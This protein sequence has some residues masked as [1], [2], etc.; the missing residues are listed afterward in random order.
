MCT[1]LNFA[2]VFKPLRTIKLGA[3][4]P[5]IAQIDKI[6]FHNEYIFILDQDGNQ[7]IFAFDTTG[8]FLGTVGQKGF[9]P[10]E[11]EYPED[12]A[13]NDTY[14]VICTSD[15]YLLW[16]DINTRQLIKRTTLP[17]HTDAI[18]AI[19]DGRFI[20]AT[21]SLKDNP[22]RTHLLELVSNGNIINGHIPIANPD[23]VE[24]TANPIHKGLNGSLLYAPTND[25]IL[26][27][28]KNNHVSIILELEKQN[29]QSKNKL[30]I[31]NYFINAPIIQTPNH[32]LFFSNNKRQINAGN[33][34]KVEINVLNIQKK[35]LSCYEKYSSDWMTYALEDMPIGFWKDSLLIW[36][37]YADGIDAFLDLIKDDK[38]YQKNLLN[39]DPI[40]ADV[41]KKHNTFDNPTLLLG[42]WK[43]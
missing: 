12:I 21:N 19:S 3:S 13:V 41:I 10:E 7:A 33:P 4:T 11:Y 43:P 2:E 42:I 30:G 5:L 32:I 25:S 8:I 38:I 39:N 15:K 26:Y 35:L 28:I 18:A 14:I 27:S 16:Y 1:E 40:A 37:L 22:Y 31:G 36:P 34:N 29:I 24:Y 17:L 23:L 6:L 9:G 20:L